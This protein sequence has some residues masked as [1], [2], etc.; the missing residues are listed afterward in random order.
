MKICN[1]S[2]VDLFLVVKL[3]KED[4]SSHVFTCFFIN[5]ICNSYFTS[6]TYPIIGYKIIRTKMCLI[7]SRC[8]R[9]VKRLLENEVSQTCCI[10]TK[11]DTCTTVP[12]ELAQ[13]WV[14][15]RYALYIWHFLS[16]NLTQNCEHILGFPV[17]QVDSL[18]GQR[19]VPGYALW[20]IQREQNGSW[21][22]HPT[23]QHWSSSLWLRYE[24]KAL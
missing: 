1:H 5:H 21:R 11:R 13:T 15:K 7:F 6:S 3:E 16:I 4:P 23:N 17:P 14:S 24:V 2:K 10:F 19:C 18:A 20:A 9:P 8:I 22:P 12:F